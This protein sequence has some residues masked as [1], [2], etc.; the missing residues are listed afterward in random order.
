MTLYTGAQLTEVNNFWG[1][2]LGQ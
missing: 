2:H 1:C